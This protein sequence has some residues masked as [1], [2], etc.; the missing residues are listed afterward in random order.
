MI[1]RDDLR[2]AV[3]SGLLSEAQAAKLT[4]LADIRRGTR[5]AMGPEDEPFELFRG[6]NEIFIVVGLVILSV[7]WWALVGVVALASEG[8]FAF[9]MLSAIGAVIVWSLSEYFVRTRRMV[10]PAITLSILFALS[11]LGAVGPWLT[12]GVRLAIGA[13]VMDVLLVVLATTGG[14]LLHF[15]R[16]RVP[17]SLAL[18]ALGAFCATFL[19]VGLATDARL[20]L[21]GLFLLASGSIYAWATLGLGLAVFA[22]AMTFDMS[23]PHRVTRRSANGFWLHVVAGAAIVNT[24]ALSL[25]A[26]P[27]PLRLA[28]LALLLMA[29]AVV[30]IVI[31]RRS[32]LVSGA[33]YTVALAGFAAEGTGIALAILIMGGTLLILGAAWER[34]RAALLDALGPAV[35][36]DR[37]P[38]AHRPG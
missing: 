10:A 6:F 18:V 35:P 4:G 8:P 7:G 38:P 20:T 5:A 11:I 24:L 27:T 23:D 32:F 28:A 13:D 15:W 31:D 17:F 36:R 25:L 34:I 21:G 3:A 16:F 14:L 2:A 9:S 37:L 30:A 29:L 26:D 33:G 22:V 1:E 12:A 19:T